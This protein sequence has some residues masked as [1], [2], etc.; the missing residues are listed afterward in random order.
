MFP[1]QSIAS[2]GLIASGGRA[3]ADIARS[4]VLADRCMKGNCR[5]MDEGEREGTAP[6]QCSG[7]IARRPIS[8]SLRTGMSRALHASSEHTNMVADNAAP[9]NINC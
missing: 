9:T 6:L 2:G 3:I 5:W 8:S 1:A 4:L 7:R